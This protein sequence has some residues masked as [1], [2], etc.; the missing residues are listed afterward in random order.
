MLDNESYINALQPSPDS[1]RL[2]T[3]V[4]RYAGEGC[5]VCSAILDLGQ[6]KPKHTIPTPSFSRGSP[7]AGESVRAYFVINP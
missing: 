2:V 6:E 1:L 3:L 4:P 7:Q 5:S